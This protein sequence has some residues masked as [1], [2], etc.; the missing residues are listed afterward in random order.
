MELYAQ[1]VDPSEESEVDRLL[2]RDGI[3]C[4]LDLHRLKGSEASFERTG[5]Y[6]RARSFIF[7]IALLLPGSGLLLSKLYGDFNDYQGRLRQTYL[8][9][10]QLF[11]LIRFCSSPLRPSV[12]KAKEPDE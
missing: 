3:D 8:I 1:D 11:Q 12:A 5:T 2:H 9:F 7:K 10:T 4:V 6:M